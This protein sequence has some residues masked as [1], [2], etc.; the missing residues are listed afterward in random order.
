MKLSKKTGLVIAIGVFVIALGG[1]FMAYSGQVDEQKQLNEQL[2]SIQA[3]L[4]RG[5]VEKLSSQQAELEQQL[6]QAQSQF[7]AVNATL[8]QPVGSVA[9]AT[10]L[11]EVAKTYGLV[12]TEV[13]SPG[14][15][16]ESLEGVTYSVISLTAK[17]EGDVPNLVSFVT[18]LNNHFTTGVVK[19]ITITIP[20]AASGDNASA[21][22][23]TSAN[24]QL[25]V[26]TYKGD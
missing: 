25:T 8:S 26:Y 11:F 16:T 3:N 2:V 21:S 20:E 18:K 19:L 23:N 24:L 6:S 5:Q 1:L 9:A 4:M 17:V 14:P 7:A 15:A 13:T 22:V 10:I 12:V